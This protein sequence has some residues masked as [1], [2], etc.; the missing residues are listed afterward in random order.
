MKKYRK[1]FYGILLLNLRDNGFNVIVG[2]RRPRQMI[3]LR[4]EF[5]PGMWNCPE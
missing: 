3:L 5:M 4:Q 2:Q 1:G